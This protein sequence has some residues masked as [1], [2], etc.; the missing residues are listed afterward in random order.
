MRIANFKGQISLFVIVSVILVVGLVSLTFFNIDRVPIFSDNTASGQVKEYV[1]SCVDLTT[2]DAMR[3]IAASGGW[4]YHPPGIFTDRDKPEQ[5]N[6]RAV[7]LNFLETIEIPYWY[8]FDDSSETFVYNI[9][10]YDTNNAYSI[11]SQV[12]RYV[13]ENLES[14]IDSFNAFENI[15]DIDYN[16]EDTQVSVDFDEE[17]IDVEVEW[18]LE[19]TEINLNSTEYVDIFNS[20]VENKLWVPYNLARDI[21]IAQ[22][23]SSFLEKRMISFLSPYQSATQRDLLPPFYDFRMTY[24]FRPW[25]LSEVEMLIKQVLNSHLSKIQFTNTDYRES[26]VDDRL[27]NNEFANSL[28]NLYT[29]D[30][31]S[32]HS[33]IDD[34]NQ[35]LFQ[36]YRNYEVRPYYELFFPSS[37]NIFPGMGDQILLPKPQAIIQLIPFFFTE[38]VAVYE[39]TVPVVFEI[40][41][42]N[43][44]DDLTFNLAIEAN[45]DHNK[46]LKENSELNID[47]QPDA[48]QNNALVCDPPHFISDYVY[49]NISD[50]VNYGNRGP[51][52]PETGIDG[53]IVTFSCKEIT[54]CYVTETEINGKYPQRNITELRMRL[55]INCD[56]GTLEVYKFGHKKLQFEDLDPRI[57]RSINLGENY[58]PSKKPMEVEVNVINSQASKFS[59]GREINSNEEGFIILEN[60]D[61]SDIV[62]VIEINSENQYDLTVDL[63][64]GNYSMQGF[65]LYNNPITIPSEEIC[66]QKGLFGG[67]ECETL[68]AID[69]DSWVR[70]GIEIE[71]V[72]FDIRRVINSNKL[73]INLIDTGVPVSY[74]T[75]SSMSNELNRLGTISTGKE[76]YL[77]QD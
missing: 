39:M 54:S 37:I 77:E 20:D 67:E 1:E 4:L 15:Y 46:P 34:N 36:R 52:D 14:C 27:R 57:S 66:Y 7:G 49:L 30:Y 11:K 47:V 50:P 51:E 32:E 38:Y 76:P 26:E 60:L 8:Y 69:I 45:I 19:I 22:A 40:K 12:K 53:A 68:P 25:D 48:N 42:N 72:E 17:R 41:S 2:N 70:G 64:P 75:L 44:N 21:T 65:L 74:D 61:D 9:P 16:R 35:R 43:L 29:K 58:M 63:M 18:P 5:F 13:T 24:D 55:P 59:A 6:K 10:E 71:Q 28:S 31:I 62:E 23:E 73:V 33:L 3:N 56:P